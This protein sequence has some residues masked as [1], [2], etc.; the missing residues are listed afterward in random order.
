MTYQAKFI[1][2]LAVILLNTVV[3]CSQ[4]FH[5]ASRRSCTLCSLEF[6]IFI[7]I[8]VTSPLHKLMSFCFFIL[9][10]TMLALL[11]NVS[12]SVHLETGTLIWKVAGKISKC[13][14]HSS[15]NFDKFAREKFVSPTI[16]NRLT[17][18]KLCFAYSFHRKL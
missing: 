15:R 10:N 2:C 5:E 12:F 3:A 1:E 16:Y 9:Y 11:E 17:K 4:Y 13:L 6:G 14:V 8:P 7:T 18:Q